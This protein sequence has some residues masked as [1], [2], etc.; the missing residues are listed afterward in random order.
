MQVTKFSHNKILKFMQI[1]D[2]AIIS[3]KDPHGHTLGFLD[4][5][6]YRFFQVAPQLYSQG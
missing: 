4:Q 6:R 1:C 5:S 2:K 3:A